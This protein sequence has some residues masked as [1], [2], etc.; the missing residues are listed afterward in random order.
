MSSKRFILNRFI[1][2]V[3]VASFSVLFWHYHRTH[4]Y[5]VVFNPE[6]RLWNEK[7]RQ[8]LLHT[9][10]KPRL[11]APSTSP[12]NLASE[13]EGRPFK[14]ARGNYR[15]KNNEVV[16]LEKR[17]GAPAR[18]KLL[19]T[20]EETGEDAY[21]SGE[22]IITTTEIDRLPKSQQGLRFTMLRELG[23]NR[24]LIGIEPAVELEKGLDILE[25]QLKLEDW[26]VD[27]VDRKILPE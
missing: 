14:N 24:Y 18:H 1:F 13:G 15:L 21:L 5:S 3:L 2:F 17:S 12:R 10:Q 6:V 23:P 7:I 26:E 16:N 25:R 8:A 9:D 20:N 19:V 27:V 4:R 22:V 11:T